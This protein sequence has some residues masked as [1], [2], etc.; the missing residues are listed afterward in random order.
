M[1]RRHPVQKKQIYIAKVAFEDIIYYTND[2][3]ELEVIIRPENKGGKLCE[4]KCEALNPEEYYKENTAVA[5]E[6]RLRMAI[7]NGIAPSDYMQM[8]SEYFK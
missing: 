8:H 5:N 1:P 6:A 4:L 2:S 3:N 7:E